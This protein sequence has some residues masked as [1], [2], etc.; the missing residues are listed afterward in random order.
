[1]QSCSR[2]P[3]L[4]ATLVQRSAALP[5]V[6]PTF[7]RQV[8]EKGTASMFANRTS[9]RIP[10]HMVRGKMHQNDIKQRSQKGKP[11]A[12]TLKKFRLTR[13]GW[14]RRRSRFRGWKKRQRSW[15][16]KSNSR[17]IQYLHR[18][19]EQKLIRQSWFMRLKYRDFPREQ[20]VNLLPIRA[21]IGCHFG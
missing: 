1:M 4:A 7:A 10:Q 21:I 8:R 2:T 12:E 14:E 16:S 17:K 9:R 5:I 11:H 6:R 20:N 15:L 13:F 3:A 19:D 18:A